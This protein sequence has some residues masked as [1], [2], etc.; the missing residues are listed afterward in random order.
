MLHYKHSPSIYPRRAMRNILYIILIL[1]FSVNRV[2]AQSEQKITPSDG[3]A[4]DEFGRSVSIDG[5]YAIVGAFGDDFASG[6]AYILQR[7]GGNWIEMAKLVT[8]DGDLEDRFGESVSISGNYAIVG[9]KG[10]DDKGTS[11]G[12]A[13]IIERQGS[14]WRVPVKLIPNDGTTGD[15]FGSSVSISGNYAIVGA[16]S[17]DDNGDLSGSAYI[18]E[19]QGNIWTE[20]TKIAASGAAERDE[21]G[22]SVSISGSYAIVGAD[23]PGDNDNASG[24]GSAYIFQ[25]KENTWIQAAKLTA[26]DAAEGDEFGYSVAISGDYAIVGANRDDDNGSGSGSAYIFERQNNTGL[27]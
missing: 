18:F 14:S 11:S 16:P 27:K 22:I 15:L 10:N 1:L 8:S 6:S 5:N 2:E 24:S 4:R 20:V 3:A 21:F 7:Q 19:R 13:Y 25:R 23:E 26:R 12:S 9:A 17:D